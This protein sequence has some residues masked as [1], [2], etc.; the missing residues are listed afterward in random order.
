MDMCGNDSRRDDRK[1]YF[2]PVRLN[3]LLGWP[4]CDYNMGNC[5]CNYAVLWSDLCRVINPL[6]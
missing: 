4:G 3:D 6:S 1:L 2:L 5:G